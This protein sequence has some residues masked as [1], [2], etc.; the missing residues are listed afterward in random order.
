MEEIIIIYLAIIRTQRI[1]IK[2]FQKNNI[3][4]FHIFFH[5][6]I[7]LKISF[8]YNFLYLI[9]LWHFYSLIKII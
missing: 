8:K 3:E 1:R 6:K 5:F 7:K 9:N 2:E 4:S